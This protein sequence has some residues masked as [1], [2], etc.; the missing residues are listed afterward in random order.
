V[1]GVVLRGRG[2]VSDGPPS[3]RQ[4][5]SGIG[6]RR[7]LGLAAMLQIRDADRGE[8]LLRALEGE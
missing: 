3:G 2:G 1:R 6:R 8:R 5:A 4:A 7:L